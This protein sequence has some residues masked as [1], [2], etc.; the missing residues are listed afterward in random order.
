[1]ALKLGEWR[2]ALTEYESVLQ[3][4]DLTEEHR[5]G[6]QRKVSRAMAMANAEEALAL[7]AD[8]CAPPPSSSA[9]DADH[10]RRGDAALDDLSQALEAAKR[11][12][13]AP[14]K[15]SEAEAVLSTAQRRRKVSLE[16]AAAKP[17]WFRRGSAAVLSAA[18]LDATSAGV[19]PAEIAAASAALTTM[20]SSELEAAR[21]AAV[22]V[23]RRARGSVRDDAS[24]GNASALRRQLSA[25]DAAVSLAREARVDAPAIASAL[26]ARSSLTEEAESL[27]R[28][29]AEAESMHLVCARRGAA[30]ARLQARCRGKVARTTTAKLRAE[31]IARSRARQQSLLKRQR[32]AARAKTVAAWSATFRIWRRRALCAAGGLLL[33]YAAVTAS[34]ILV[35]ALRAAS[36]RQQ[37]PALPRNGHRPWHHASRDGSRLPQRALLL[38]QSG[39]PLLYQ[40]SMLT[41][42]SWRYFGAGWLPERSTTAEVA[43]GGRLEAPMVRRLVLS[44]LA[45]L[46]DLR[47]HVGAAI[48]GVRRLCDALF[49]KRR[50]ELGRE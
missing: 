25:L 12:G 18:I 2:R 27:A 43:A 17:S 42:S 7:H 39:Q 29:E 3:R 23:V 49:I 30:A 16:L 33:A 37:Y 36:S 20:A 38:H 21:R 4:P 46:A 24:G 11:A 31:A 45:L 48:G 35:S 44:L 5:G 32:A 50:R 19:E 47:M 8:C 34:A 14:A 26:Q 41:S 6:V 1:M 9:G 15:I 22:D 13:V 40:S 28:A 10:P